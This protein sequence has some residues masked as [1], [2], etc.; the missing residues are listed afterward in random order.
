MTRQAGQ[1]PLQLSINDL[2]F[3]QRALAAPEQDWNANFRCS[4]A[5]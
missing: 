2:V 5:A 3:F 4:L 1:E